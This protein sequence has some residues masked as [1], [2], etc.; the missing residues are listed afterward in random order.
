MQVEIKSAEQGME[1]LRRSSK[2][3]RK[4]TTGL[5]YASS[6]SHSIFTLAVQ[7]GPQAA[8]GDPDFSRISFVDLAGTSG[9]QCH[10]CR[11]CSQDRLRACLLS[12][13]LLWK[14]QLDRRD[15]S[16][17][18]ASSIQARHSTFPDQTMFFAK[19][20]QSM[21][22]QNAMQGLYPGECNMHSVLL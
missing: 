6:R 10:F 18:R 13:F 5:N 22:M 19:I 1:V 4:A 14:L 21:A 3:R 12:L 8:G 15:K 16:I 11:R 17:T 2:Q 9:S 20:V 7:W